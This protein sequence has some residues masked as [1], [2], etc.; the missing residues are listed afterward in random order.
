MKKKVVLGLSGGVDSSVSAYLL[1]EQGYDVTCLFMKNWDETDESGLCTAY[2]DSEDALRVARALDM[3][4]YTVNFETE[5][6]DR[7]FTYFLRELEAG[8]TPNPDVMCNQEIKF[9]AFL[10]FAMKIEADFI[11]M[12]HYAQIVK[13]G[14]RF[15]LARGAD[16]SKDQSYFLSRI[17]EAAL[18]KTVFP[19]GHLEKTEVRRIAEEQNLLTA[20]KKDSTGICFIGERNF[21]EFIDKYL[22]SKPGDI[23]DVDGGVIGKHNGL[24]HYTLGQRRGIGIGGVKTG[25]PW[26][27]AEKDQKKNILYVCQ[28]EGHK[29]L[30]SDYLICED[31]RWIAGVP[32]E[33]P[34]DYTAKF[35]YRQPDKEVR[36]SYEAGKIRID[37]KEPVKAITPGQIAVV[38]DGDICL[39]GGIIDKKG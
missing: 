6:W 11:A 36:L 30:Y 23:V 14:D 34:R 3:P 38:Y 29:A 21:N 20:K 39:G 15:C 9:N 27:V 1:K 31:F 37:F 5:Y 16:Q 25:E 8:R 28:G 4:F 7:V 13:D 18:S 26:F 17:D 32:P 19:I 12:G 35:R 2:Q 24:I 10:D 22:L 33:I